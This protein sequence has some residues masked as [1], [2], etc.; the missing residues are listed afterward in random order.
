VQQSARLA[1]CS[2]HYMRMSCLSVCAE[3]VLFGGSIRDNILYGKP[4][5]TFEEVQ[6]V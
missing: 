2:Q 3:P 6:E 4:D 5:A 1:R